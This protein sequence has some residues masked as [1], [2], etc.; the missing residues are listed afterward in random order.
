MTHA[1]LIG[2]LTVRRA[3]GVLGISLPFVLW[4]VGTIAL[5][6]PRQVDISS[7][8]HTPLGD[9][10]V[11]ALCAI[12]VFLFSYRGYPHGGDKWWHISDNA[13]AN[14]AGTCAIGAALFPV[15]HEHASALQEVIGRFHTAWAVGL[16]L[17]FAYFCICLFTNR[18]SPSPIRVDTGK[19]HRNRIY[20]TCGSA[21]LIAIVSAFVTRTLAPRESLFF[22][23]TLAVCAF[24]VS[25]LV[26]GE[27]F[28][29][30]TW[31]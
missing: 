15:A 19:T 8:Y 10:F 27:T 21:I 12:A 1:T 22:L 24:G 11:G 9:V 26:K 23:E 25:W 18:P 28:W 4:W 20:Y 16:F 29:P 7:Y 13:A 6:I 5:D 3:V 30:K 17:M 2:Y 14:I 31:R